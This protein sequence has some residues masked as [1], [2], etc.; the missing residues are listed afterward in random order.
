[1]IAVRGLV[2]LGLAGSMLA[3][4]SAAATTSHY[5]FDRPT[6]IAAGSGHLWIANTGGNSVTETT[7]QGALVRTIRA[8]KYGFHSPDAITVSGAKVFVVNRNGSVTELS[9]TNGSLVRVIHGARYA[10]SRPVAIVVDDGKAWVVNRRSSSVTE[11]RASDGSLVRVLSHGFG[12]HHPVAIAAGGNRIWVLNSTGASTTDASAG[13]VSVISATTSAL[14]RNVHAAA[15]GLATPR[16]IAFDGTHLW[17]TDTVP[18]TVTELTASGALVRIVTDASARNVY[19]EQGTAVAAH[20]GQVYVISPPG[21]SPMV[22]RIVAA[23][24]KGMW[25]ECNTN[26]PDPKFVNPAGL[27]VHGQRVWVVSPGNNSLAELHVS[28][29]LLVHRFG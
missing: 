2:T 3:G 6:A 27:A 7:Y 18:G 12:L 11:F 16:G 9:A 29:G 28:T 26:T 10:F 24:A 20:A 15:D 13:S 21:S 5:G 19:L 17:I 8:A 25:F 14:L 4:G 23:T 1:M 22:S